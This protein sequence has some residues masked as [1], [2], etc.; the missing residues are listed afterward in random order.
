MTRREGWLELRFMR[1][2]RGAVAAGVG[3]GRAGALLAAILAWA[4]AL[5]PATL[6]HA[7]QGLP[8][9]QDLAADGAAARSR[10]VPILLFFN[11]FDCPYCERAL[12]QFLVP[13]ERDP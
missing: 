6:A 13:M 4:F 3:V 9:A 12:R 5:S 2:R 10:Q 11:R 7:A 1:A 8:A